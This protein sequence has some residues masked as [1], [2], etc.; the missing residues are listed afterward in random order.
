MSLPTG[1]QVRAR[2][3]ARGLSQVALA[4][5]VALTRQS[6][7]AIEA[8]R[9]I[10][11]VDVALRLARALECGV[12]ELFAAAERA[13]HL[14]VELGGEVHARRMALAF[15]RER[16]VGLPL[17]SESP[18][19]AADALVVKA[20]GRRAT[21]AT[22][23]SL[24]E[25]REGLVLTGCATALGVLADRMQS[26][27]G[28]GR[29]LWLPS[30]TTGALKA[31]AAGHTHVA[32]VHAVASEDEP[33]ANLATVRRT[34]PRE[35][36]T[37][38][39]LARWEVGLVT[40]RGDTRIHRVEDLALPGIRLAA[41]ERGAGARQLLDQ[42]LRM[43]GVALEVARRA[44]LVATGHLE[45]ARAVRLGAADVGVATRDVALGLELRFLP[46][47]EE[48]YDVVFATALLA[49]ARVERLL[50]L[51]ASSGGRSDLESLGYDTSSTGQRV[52]EVQA[53]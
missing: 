7:G 37:V 6:L 3:E 52:A 48:R 19:A 24:A 20:R 45:V 25:A 15:L 40:R 27:R 47:A 26:T 41:R 39:T 31:L 33:D 29:Y 34:A 13:P 8:G 46:L 9:A 36:L 35:P 44:P 12:E 43:A 17:G 16:W 11:G 5:R 28:S 42:R 21:V 32:G 30:S 4:S 22:L 1:N 49:D 14:E 23:R 2:R 53:A 38:V 10:P 51:L 18:R 50:D